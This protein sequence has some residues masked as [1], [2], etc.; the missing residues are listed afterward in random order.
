MGMML[1]RMKVRQ[2][3]RE[4]V[5]KGRRETGRKEGRGQ[6]ARSEGKEG[7]LERRNTHERLDDSRDIEVIRWYVSKSDIVDEVHLD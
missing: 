3:K 1:A 5:A 2:W 7:E 6:L 4:K